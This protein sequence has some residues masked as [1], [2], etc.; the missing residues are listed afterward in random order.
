MAKKALQSTTDSALANSTTPEA[1]A[2]V[3]YL[4][5]CRLQFQNPET[6]EVTSVYITHT[7]KERFRIKIFRGGK[8]I[9]AKYVAAE[10]FADILSNLK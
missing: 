6:F 3:K 8:C 1:Y 10:N 4:R 5:S 2:S 9:S 7:D